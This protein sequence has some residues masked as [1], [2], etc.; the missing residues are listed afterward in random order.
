MFEEF[1]IDG[2]LSSF[3]DHAGINIG[4]GPECWGSNPFSPSKNRIDPVLPK[5]PRLASRSP[6]G[7]ADDLGRLRLV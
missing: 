3:T 4:G 6:A 2:D 7:D 5:S 1:V